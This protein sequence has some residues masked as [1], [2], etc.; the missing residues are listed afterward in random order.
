[1]I[2]WMLWDIVIIGSAHIS[3]D[4]LVHSPTDS[5]RSGGI[6]PILVATL[7]ML[8]I[9]L[10]VTLPLGLAVAIWL[11]DFNGRQRRLNLVLDALAGVPSVVYGL[12]GNA[13]FCIYLGFGY[14]ILSG[15]LTLACMI[16]PVFIRN[17]EMGLSMVDGGWRHG[18]AALGMTQLGTLWHILLPA[19]GPAIIAGL[20]LAIGRASAE[21]A[22]LLFTSGYVDRMPA[23]V[24]DS[25]RV[26]AVH[27][28]DLSM[29]ITGGDSA[30]YAT[31]LTLIAL[32]TVLNL[33]AQST[34]D[35]WLSR[36]ITQP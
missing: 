36:R 18:A 9:T 16:L 35:R 29:N 31:A 3:L 33:L 10:L 2:V 14:S 17:C 12:F 22:A 21:T 6:A 13:F 30:A 20:I 7:W 8:G 25:G 23:S 19:A 1:M 32:I 34:I 27:I 15:G 5:G 11:S 26:L 24:L 28:Y 4:F